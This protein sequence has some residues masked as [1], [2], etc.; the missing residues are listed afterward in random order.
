MCDRSRKKNLDTW[1]HAE[2]IRIIVFLAGTGPE[3][4]AGKSVGDSGGDTLLPLKR[5][6]KAAITLTVFRSCT[7]FEWRPQTATTRIPSHSRGSGCACQIEL[8]VPALFFAI[9]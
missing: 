3:L 9:P 2:P 7:L 8:F 5:R 4:R 6:W 1:L